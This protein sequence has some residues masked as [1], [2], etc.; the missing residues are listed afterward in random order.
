NCFC[1]PQSEI[2]ILEAYLANVGGTKWLNTV[3]QYGGAGNPMPLWV[4]NDGNEDH[5]WYDNTSAQP[6]WYQNLNQGAGGWA[7]GSNEV[8][9]EVARAAAHFNVSGDRSAILLIALPPSNYFVTDGLGGLGCGFHQWQ[10]TTGNP[11]AALT[12]MPNHPTACAHEGTTLGS[13]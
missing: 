4:V 13:V 7:F 1:D 9:P 3:T 12:Y 11:Y 10:T 5:F 2:P 6:G 8:A